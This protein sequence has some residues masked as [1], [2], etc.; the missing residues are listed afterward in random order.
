MF[1]LKYQKTKKKLQ[2][3]LIQTIRIT[4]KK[5]EVINYQFINFIYIT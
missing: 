4:S 2:K 1:L 5:L 3:R